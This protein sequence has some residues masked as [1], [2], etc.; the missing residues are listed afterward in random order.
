MAGC[1]RG[2]GVLL[3]CRLNP[4]LI[5]FHCVAHRLQLGVGDAANEVPYFVEFESTLRALYTHFSL[6]SQRKD[7]LWK[8]YEVCGIVA[9]EI[10]KWGATRWL[11]RANST[12]SIFSGYQAILEYLLVNLTDCMCAMLWAQFTTYS[13]VM[14]VYFLQDILQKQKALAIALQSDTVNYSYV[15]QLIDSTL[16]GIHDG[17]LAEKPTYGKVFAEFLTVVDSHVGT[18]ASKQFL[19]FD[20]YKC[21]YSR[22]EHQKIMTEVVRPFAFHLHKCLKERFPPSKFLAALDVFERAQWPLHV[23]GETELEKTMH[24]NVLKEWAYQQFAVVLERMTAEK[25]NDDG[26]PVEQ[27]VDAEDAKLEFATFFFFW[28]HVRRC[29]RE[30][31]IRRH[32]CAFAH[33]NTA[34]L[35]GQSQGAYLLSDGYPTCQCLQ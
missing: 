28:P 31:I 4:Y 8:A 11:S 26:A 3:A 30:T 25:T 6:S 15:A 24:K 34:R 27:I 16:G 33:A 19:L 35:A 13:V 21:D 14:V 9:R 20:K 18:A 29:S 12:G 2:L 10:A 22:V 32:G 23:C 1:K 5:T 17:Y 7:A